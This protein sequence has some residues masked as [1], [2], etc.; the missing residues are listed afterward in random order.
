[1]AFVELTFLNKIFFHILESCMSIFV[2]V[3]VGF[4]FFQAKQKDFNDGLHCR[5]SQSV[6]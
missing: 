6:P 5:E 2:V 3:V 1:M 4:N